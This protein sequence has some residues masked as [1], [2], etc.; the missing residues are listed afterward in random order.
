MTIG[1][2]QMGKED[3]SQTIWYDLE[4]GLDVIRGKEYRA[5]SR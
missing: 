4:A 1:I 3:F 5:V 2:G